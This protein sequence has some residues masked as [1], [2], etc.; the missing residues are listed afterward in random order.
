MN[1]IIVI[2]GALVFDSWIDEMP[3]LRAHHDEDRHLI[4]EG[5]GIILDLLI[6]TARKG[7][8]L[9]VGGQVLPGKR[10]NE[11]FRTCGYR[12]NTEANSRIP[13]PTHSVSS[14]FTRYRMATSICRSN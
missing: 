11:R 10:S 8:V 5:A 6:K 12:W 3:H 7:H 9:H 1:E 13:R 2:E 14:H 4:Y